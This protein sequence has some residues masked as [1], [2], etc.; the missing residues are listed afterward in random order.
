LL[1]APD[2]CGNDELSCCLWILM[3]VP[4]RV[5]VFVMFILILL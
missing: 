4:N 5:I 3:Y 1:T 2:V